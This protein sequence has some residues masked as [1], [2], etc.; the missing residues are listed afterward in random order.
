MRIILM[1]LMEL[2]VEWMEVDL[3]NYYH[4]KHYI[5]GDITYDGRPLRYLDSYHIYPRNVRVL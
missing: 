1:E 4:D 3:I 5:F 2:V